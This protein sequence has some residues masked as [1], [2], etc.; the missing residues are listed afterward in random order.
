MTSLLDRRLE[1]LDRSRPKS[2][3]NDNPRSS[4]IPWPRGLL[5][6][7]YR[8]SFDDLGHDAGPDGLAAFAN[9]EA[10]AFLHGDRAFR[11]QLDLDLDVFAR[12]AHFRL[13]AVGRHQFGDRACDVGRPEIKLRTIPC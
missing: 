3:S 8:Q 13:A 11:N 6:T 4:G 1:I 9:G 10:Q 5:Y 2:H 7:A 12:H